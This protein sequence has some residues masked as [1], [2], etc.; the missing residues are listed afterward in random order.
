MIV[1]QFLKS[2][3]EQF[4][5]DLRESNPLLARARQGQVSP[6]AVAAYLRNVHYLVLHTPVCLE[7]ARRRALQLGELELARYFADKQTEEAGH[8]VWAENDLAR[9]RR[10]FDLPKRDELASAIV[11][12]VSYLQQL[13]EDSPSSYLAYILFAEYLTVLLGPEWLD[14]L[15]E[16]CGIPSQML[17]VVAQHAVLDR[18]HSS[19][20]LRE[21]DELVRDADAVD[22]LRETLRRAM[23]YFATFTEEIA[24]LH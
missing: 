9:V 10:A 1:S 14:A 13:V 16:R 15:E 5:A 2:D 22:A 19:Q 21:I 24:R 18:D 17:S 3:I 23:V 12:L 6:G 4:A 7:G 8:D 20:G 11:G